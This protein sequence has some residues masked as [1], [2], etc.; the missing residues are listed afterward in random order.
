MNVIIPWDLEHDDS[1][2]IHVALLEAGKEIER[3]QS[4][5]KRWRNLAEEAH[6]NLCQLNDHALCIDYLAWKVKGR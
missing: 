2:P 1:N 6:L 5:L 3:L 4:E